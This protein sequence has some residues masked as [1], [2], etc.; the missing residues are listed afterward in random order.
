MAMLS[1]KFQPKL[2][3]GSG[4][5]HKREVSLFVLS[6][7]VFFFLMLNNK[8]FEVYS[9]RLFFGSWGLKLDESLLHIVASLYFLV[10]EQ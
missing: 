8:M 1:C 3:S 6:R 4:D 10:L 2:F 7:A 5:C 9:L